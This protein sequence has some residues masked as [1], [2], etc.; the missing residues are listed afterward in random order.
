MPG[1]RTAGGTGRR[2]GTPPVHNTAAVLVSWEVDREQSA[3]NGSA[4]GLLTVV[5]RARVSGLVALCLG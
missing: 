4:A 5:E 3:R 2:V 1:P